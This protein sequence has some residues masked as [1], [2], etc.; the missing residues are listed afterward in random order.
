MMTILPAETKH[1]ESIA[2]LKANLHY[3]EALQRKAFD[4]H[5]TAICN[6][7]ETLTALNEAICRKN[8]HA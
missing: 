6:Y 8:N 1:P 2:A 4:A 5:V 7:H 3:A